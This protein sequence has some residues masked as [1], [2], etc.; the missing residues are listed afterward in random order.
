MKHVPIIRTPS[1]NRISKFLDVGSR[2]AKKQKVVRKEVNV[3][4]DPVI[5]TGHDDSTIRFWTQN[6]IHHQ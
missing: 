4:Y 3:N 2:P 1:P 6:V 5:V